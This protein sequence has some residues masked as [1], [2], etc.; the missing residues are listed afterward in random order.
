MATAGE[1]FNLH[2][3]GVADEHGRVLALVG[4]SGAGKTTATRLLARRLAYLSDETVSI[5]P[6]GTC[7]PTRSRSPWSSI[8]STAQRKEQLSPDDLGLLPT[9]ATAPWPVSSC[10]T[11]TP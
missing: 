10:C 11:R 4:P 5:A 2:A 6:D 9:P 8:P 7:R 1:R 3:G